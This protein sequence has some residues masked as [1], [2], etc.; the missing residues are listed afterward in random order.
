M[1]LWGADRNRLEARRPGSPPGRLSGRRSA[2]S[3][4]TFLADREA[5]IFET[6]ERCQDRHWDFLVRASQ[7]R[8]LA[9]K[10]GSV[11]DAVVA[12]PVVACFALKLRSRP[13]R[14][15][16]DKKTG[17]P[18]RVRKAH[19]GRTVELEVRTCT[20]RL[21]AP[22]RP[23]H[24][25]GVLRVLASSSGGCAS[26]QPAGSPSGL[27]QARRRSCGTPH[28]EHSEPPGNADT[29]REEETAREGDVC[30]T[31]PSAAARA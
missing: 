6:I 18:K 30:P 12:G 31:P 7:P 19:G 4:Y 15:T 16:R 3:R 1:D 17:K 20:V 14:A 10:E 8:A 26:G 25:C 11:F 22:W 5:D 13:R 9:D 24:P 23:G 29:R 21:R 2:P 28:E 27:K